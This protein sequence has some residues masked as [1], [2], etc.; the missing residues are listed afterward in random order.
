MLDL[1][2]TWFERNQQKLRYY[3]LNSTDSGSRK[4]SYTEERDCSQLP[5]ASAGPQASQIPNFKACHH[6]VMAAHQ[7]VER[8]AALIKRCFYWPRV[9]KDVEM[10]CK[11]CTACGRCK[12]T[13]QGHSELQ[14]PRHGAFNERVSVNLIGPLHRTERGNEYNFVI[15]DHFTTWIESAAVPSKEPMV[16]V[17]VIIWKWVYKHGTPLNIHNDR[18]TE[19][20]AAM[21]RCMCD[22]LRIKKLIL[23][24][25]SYSPMVP[26]K[27]AI[28]PYYPC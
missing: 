21:H 11:R 22:L 3:G 27:G 4:T 20:T 26:W 9:Q 6:H 15:Q 16:V 24:H 23:R 8:T 19:F 14:Q 2:G 25:I 18:G 12:A 17:D 13:V 28:A 5:M 7:G 1:R 10:W